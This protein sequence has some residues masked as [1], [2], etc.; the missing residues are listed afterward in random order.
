MNQA[1][2]QAASYFIRRAQRSRQFVLSATPWIAGLTVAEGDIVQ[3][4]GLAFEAQNGGTTT[5]GNGP[6]NSGGASFVG[7][8]GV[9]WLHLPLLLVAP[10]AI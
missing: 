8:D 6:N 10:A 5:G 3:N 9:Q 4:N 7:S 1:A 2:R